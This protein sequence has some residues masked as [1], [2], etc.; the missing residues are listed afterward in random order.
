MKLSFGT[1]PQN[2]SAGSRSTNTFSC[3]FKD[4]KSVEIPASCQN[5]TKW[6]S[7][8]F[9]DGHSEHS[10]DDIELSNEGLYIKQLEIEPNPNYDLPQLTPLARQLQVGLW[11]MGCRIVLVW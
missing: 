4:G 11:W 8:K 1:I 3:L 10:M 7:K 9:D 6:C 2:S 5:K